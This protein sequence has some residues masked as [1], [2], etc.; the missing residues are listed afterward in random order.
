V[1]TTA[2]AGIE[3]AVADAEAA[4]RQTQ[5]DRIRQELDALGDQ[6]E[7]LNTDYFA[8]SAR[9]SAIET[10]L[11]EAREKLRWFEAELDAQRQLLN[12][13]VANIYKHGDM[14]PMD[15]FFNNGSLSEAFTQISL[16]F[17]IGEQDAQ[18]LEKLQ[19]QKDKVETTKNALDQLY[20]QQK[21]IT[22]ELEGR[23]KAIEDKMKEEATLLASI[24]AQTKA[25]LDQQEAQRRQEQAQ[26]VARFM[27]NTNTDQISLRPGTICF[28]AIQY[29]GVPYVWG[30]E[31]PKIGLDCSGLVKV[32]FKKFGVDLPHFAASQ[33]Q[34]GAAVAYSNMQP[35]DL[36]FFGNPIHHVG[37]YMG[38][39]YYI[40][41]PKR[42]DV[43]KISKL[44]DRNDFTCARRIISILPS[45]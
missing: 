19:D 3:Q 28:E 21:E 8:E 20:A 44:S 10:S 24:D 36:V 23:K 1:D 40:Q 25:I 13:R 18:L 26:L 35:G 39:G 27:Q 37:I 5:A 11:N 43:V 2:T 38:E 6:L 34:L 32:V 17:K 33:A 16:L 29:L 7:S 14:A 31:D 9:L 4:V 30:G 41:A 15:A 42:N 22:A 45:Q 12:D